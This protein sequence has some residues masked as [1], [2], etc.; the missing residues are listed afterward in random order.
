MANWLCPSSRRQLFCA[1][2]S[3]LKTMASAVLLDRHPFDR[4]VWRTVAK[5]VSMG[6]V[7]RRCYQCSAG[8]S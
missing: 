3:S 4:M 6:L 7:V 2:S 8:K 1:P 5:V